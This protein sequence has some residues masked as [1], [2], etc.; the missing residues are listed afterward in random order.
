MP[1]RCQ[2]CNWRGELPS[3]DSALTQAPAPASSERLD[4]DR[5]EPPDDNTPLDSA[6]EPIR[7]WL[8][9]HRPAPDDWLHITNVQAAQ[10]LLAR[11]VVTEVSL[12]H[13]LGACLECRELPE[14]R[15]GT[16]YDNCPHVP[17]GYDLCI[18]MARTGHW[19]PN[20]PVV[21]SGNI[22][23]AARMRGLILR[24]WR[25]PGEPPPSG[26]H[27]SAEEAEAFTGQFDDLRRE[28]QSAKVSTC[29]A[30]GRPTVYRRHR[31]SGWDRLR[32]NALG[33]VPVRCRACGWEGWIKGS[34]MVRLEGS[35]SR[36][37]QPVVDELDQLDE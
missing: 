1:F 24:H 34:I 3:I 29:V 32:S 6:E 37:V 14:Y 20:P 35:G 10:R 15:V 28:V 36:P 33:V 30:C 18:W 19:P 8:D 12:D 21:H 25:V 22:E 11:G 13:D 16:V 27:M 17:S 23:G 2:S 7:L 26:Q 4:L 9:D 31:R 5:L